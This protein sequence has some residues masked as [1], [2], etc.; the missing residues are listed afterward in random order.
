MLTHPCRTIWKH[1]SVCHCQTCLHILSLLLTQFLQLGNP[2]QKFSLHILMMCQQMML[3]KIIRQVHLTRLPISLK[4]PLLYSIQQ[5]F[6]LHIHQFCLLRLD[7]RIYYPLRRELSVWIGVQ[8][9][10]WPISCNIPCICTASLALMNN[11]PNLASAAN[12]VTASII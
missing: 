2:R 9:W 10:E 1:D 4:L 7:T 6:K 12:N 5:P 3:C 11:A 8:G